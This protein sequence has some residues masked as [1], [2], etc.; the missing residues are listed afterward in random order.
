MLDFDRQVLVSF[1]SGRQGDGY[2]PAS[3]EIMGILKQML[4][5]MNK[6]LAEETAAEASSV[7]TYEELMAA[8]KKEVETLSHAIETKMGRVGELGV[9]IA[10]MKNDLEDT[11]ESLGED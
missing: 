7:Q 1:L 8:K 9:N 5:E 10:M 6:D 3:S 11:Q 4:D 2:A